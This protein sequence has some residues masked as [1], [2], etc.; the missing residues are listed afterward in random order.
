ME[1]ELEKVIPTAVEEKGDDGLDA[2]Q[3]KAFESIMT[4]I[5]GGGSGDGDAGPEASPEDPSEAEATDDFSAELE[6]V[7]QEADSQE[8]R[9]PTR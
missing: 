7:V 3:Q 5:E 9:S 2:D 6:K 1:A 4:Q 8:S